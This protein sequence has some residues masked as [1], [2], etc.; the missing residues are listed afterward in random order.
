MS[1]DR[2]LVEHISRLAYI[3]LTSAEIEEMATQLST[4][5]EHVSNLQKVD[6]D[7]VKP[8]GHSVS[9]HD[10]MRD[11]YVEPSWPVAEVLA[12]APK[13]EDDLFEVQAVL[14]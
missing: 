2:Q 11:D 8:T 5:L 12:N 4:V 14:D 13:R 7:G 9:A 3:D 6:T 1:I 10:V